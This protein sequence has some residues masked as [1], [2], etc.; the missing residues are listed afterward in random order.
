MF[1][2]GAVS[3]RRS[4]HFLAGQT[5]GWRVR[6][7]RKGLSLLVF[8][9][10]AFSVVAGAHASV[11]SGPQPVDTTQLLAWLTGG[12]PGGRLI[13]LVQE[14]GLAFS[15]SAIEIRQ[16]ESAG[17]DAKLLRLLS[18]TP[19]A[20]GNR[21]RSAVSTPLANAALLAHREHFHE[22]ERELHEA[23]KTD[24][25]NAALHFALGAMHR[26]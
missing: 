19:P 4:D 16:M 9:C 7:K 18:T 24:P 14:R 11:S 21:L 2:T 26:Q 10:I 3:Y 5:H 13:R 22:A 12:I 25:Q 17:A 6:V 20:A 8:F 15:P 1:L 23:L